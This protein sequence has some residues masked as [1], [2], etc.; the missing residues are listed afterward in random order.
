MRVAGR[1]PWCA[2]LGRQAGSWLIPAVWLRGLPSCAVVLHHRPACSAAVRIR[3]S[4]ATMTK[5]RLPVD[6][7]VLC[8]S[9]LRH[10]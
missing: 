4:A 3:V 7:S 2:F 1:E 8:T 9:I 6:V 10:W 5:A